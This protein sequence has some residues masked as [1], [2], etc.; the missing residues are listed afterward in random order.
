MNSPGRDVLVVGGNNHVGSIM[1]ETLAI[2]AS[3]AMA[4]NQI[5]FV[6]PC[7]GYKSSQLRRCVDRPSNNLDYLK[8]IAALEKPKI[9]AHKI[10]QARKA[11]FR[12]KQRDGVKK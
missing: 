1:S 11:I 8:A 4:D 5:F 2:S 9:E 6:N 3:L 12:L 7:D 10:K